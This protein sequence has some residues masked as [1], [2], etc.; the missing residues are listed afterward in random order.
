MDDASFK[1]LYEA[2]DD[3]FLIHVSQPSFING[4]CDQ[5]GMSMEALRPALR[6]LL[7]DGLIRMYE[8]TDDDRELTLMEALEVI[9]QDT[10]WIAPGDD[11]EPMTVIYGLL[12]TPTGDEQLWPEWEARNGKRR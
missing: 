9:D 3:T 7:H 10:H 1:L 2:H 11:G 5:P 4:E 8:V 6:N 12:T